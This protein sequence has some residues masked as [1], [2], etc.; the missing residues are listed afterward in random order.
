MSS[1]SF[2]CAKTPAVFDYLEV[3]YN[4]RRMHSRLGYMLPVVYEVVQ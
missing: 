4:R 1:R 3:F 2:C